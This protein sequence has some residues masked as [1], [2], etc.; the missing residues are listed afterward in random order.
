[1]IKKLLLLLLFSWCC[2]VYGQ[3]IKTDVLVIGNGPS[4]IAAAIQSARS[5][6]KTVLV[7]E[8]IGIRVDEEKLDL[9]E[10]LRMPSGIWGEFLNHLKDFYKTTPGFDTT[11]NTK[12]LH[13]AKNVGDSILKKMADTVKKLTEEWN[14]TFTSVQKS[15]DGWEVKILKDGKAEEIKARIIIDCTETGAI[16]EKVGAKPA[17]KITLRQIHTSFNL[18]RTAIAVGETWPPLRPEENIVYN[19]WYI[20]LKDIVP[21]GAENLLVTQ[22]IL[23]GGKDANYLPVELELGQGAGATAAFCAFFKTTTAHLNVRIIQGELLDF[24]ADLVPYVDVPATD[25]NWRQ[26][27]Q[28]S[29]TGLLG[30][31]SFLMEDRPMI[32]AEI[33]PVL[34]EIYTRA[35]LWFNREKPGDKFTIGNTLSFISDYTLTD[36]AIL[37]TSIQK[38]WKTQFKFKSDFDLNQPITRRE[39]A[40]LANKYLNP[41]ARTVDLNG[42]LVN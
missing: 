30:G 17:A 27:Q 36:P 15:G 6:V 8:K 38:S 24:K 28:I 14:S 13:F 11:F 1:M 16:A 32:T 41:F 18:Y 12:P 22:A 34:T 37:K 5:K 21:T 25:I 33:K 31:G 35:F 42:R 19:Y 20:P 9:E 7:M 40:V 29:A 39:F 4:A 2:A 26:I 3:T 23:P 10:N